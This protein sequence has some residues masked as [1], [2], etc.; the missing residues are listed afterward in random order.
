MVLDHHGWLD[1][2]NEFFLDTLQPRVV[3]IP[4]WHA[5]HPDHGVLRRLLSAKSKPDLFIT[6]LLDA[7]RAIFSYLGPVF[8]STEG[9]VVT[10]VSAGGATYRVVILDDANPTQLVCGARTLLLPLK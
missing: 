8:K 10:R 1:T 4:A 3:I 2:T 6:S 7:P 9:H 5:T